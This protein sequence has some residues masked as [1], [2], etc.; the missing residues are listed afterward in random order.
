MELNTDP[1]TS[2]GWSSCQ[3]KLA[4]I[5]RGLPGSGKS[6]WVEQFINAQPIDIANG[7]RQR[8]YFSTDKLFYIDGKYR[9]NVNRLSEYHQRN[10]TA[11]IHA[12]S[13]G[14][15]IVICD[16]TNMARWEFMTYD[17]AAKA[18]GYQVREVLI[19]DP[20]DDAHQQLCAQRNQHGVSL[21]HIQSM[22][23]KFEPF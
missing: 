12:L 8:G 11:F 13:R 9:F 22:A 2:S 20:L 19:G 7:I 1:L 17:A 3:T 21:H 16:N 10:L 18:L 5:M 23:T 15:P 6:Y 14:E 4:I